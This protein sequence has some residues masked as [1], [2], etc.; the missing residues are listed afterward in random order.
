MK[1]LSVNFIWLVIVLVLMAPTSSFGAA[2]AGAGTDT[3]GD[4]IDDINEDL[5]DAGSDCDDDDADGDGI[6]NY[7]DTDDDGD[8]IPTATEGIVDTDGDLTPDYLDLDSD[9]D[10]ILDAVDLERLDIHLLIADANGPYFL[11]DGLG[12]TLDGSGSSTSDGLPITAYDWDIETDGIIDF[13][14]ADPVLNLTSADF[15]F[16]LSPGIYDIEL[17]V[18]DNAGFVDTDSTALVASLSPVPVPATIWLFSTALIGLVGFR[19][20]KK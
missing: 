10:T 9:N 8:S 14:S 15:A 3:D 18:T 7:L 17:R 16:L 1:S 2:C 6:F 11:V 4:G 20:Q 13:S 5:D 19:K 12:L